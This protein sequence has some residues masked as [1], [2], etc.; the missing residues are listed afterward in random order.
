MHPQ[1]SFQF[2]DKE[3]RFWNN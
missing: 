1:N 3:T 2:F